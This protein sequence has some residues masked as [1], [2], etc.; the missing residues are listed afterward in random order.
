[1]SEIQIRMPRLGEGVEKVRLIRARSRPGQ[2]VARDQIIA[3]VET[4]KANME[5]ECPFEGVV[6]GYAIA[7][8]EELNVGQVLLTLESVDQN[9]AV[10][11]NGGDVYEIQISRALQKRV[12]ERG[13]SPK[14][15]KFPGS[16]FALRPDQ[17]NLAVHLRDSLSVST[18]TVEI[19]L[20]WDALV[21]ARR[22]HFAGLRPSIS[23]LIC[24]ATGRA[25]LKHPVF[26]CVRLGSGYFLPNDVVIGY[27]VGQPND[28]LVI[29]RLPAARDA[30]LERFLGE[31]RAILAGARPSPDQPPSLIISDLSS[32]GVS[33]ARPVVV[34]P[35]VA[36]LLVCAPQLIAAPGDGDE[37]V[38]HRRA[39]LVLAFD[40]GLI[41]GVGSAAFLTAVSETLTALSEE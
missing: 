14:T 1:V 20:D 30:G 36:T 32:Y 10:D 5:I 13:S 18:A 37:V 40:H 4:S 2:F 39:V 22:R 41:N 9:A 25:L 17:A 21:A 3:D 6:I 31:M 35:S 19:L 23:E 12:G 24:F 26:Q 29:A 8:G 16:M 7:D 33:G 27:A 34:S 28:G 11:V 15:P 38:W